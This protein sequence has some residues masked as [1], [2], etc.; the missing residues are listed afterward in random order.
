MRNSIRLT[1]GHR[2]ISLGHI[3]LDFDGRQRTAS[4]T[5]ANST[6]IPSPVYL[7]TLPRCSLTLDRRGHADAP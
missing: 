2:G 4:T 6:S 1:C 5:L 3:A 7:M